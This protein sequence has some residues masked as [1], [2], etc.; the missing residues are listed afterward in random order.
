VIDEAEARQTV[1]QVIQ[2]AFQQG[3]ANAATFPSPLRG[4]EGNQ[5]YFVKVA[6]Q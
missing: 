2:E 5:E 6:A 1:Q 3:F 4:A